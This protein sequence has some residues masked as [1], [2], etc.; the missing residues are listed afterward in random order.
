MI[1][2]APQASSHSTSKRS[3]IARASSIGIDGCIFTPVCSSTS[4]AIVA[5]RH[6]GAMS[7]SSPPICTTVVPI[8]SI[9]DVSTISSVRSIMSW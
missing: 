1:L 7:T 8:A 4:S 2:P 9:S 5:R 6:G 3:A